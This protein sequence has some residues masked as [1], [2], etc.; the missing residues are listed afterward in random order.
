M[1]EVPNRTSQL[2]LDM[3]HT[4]DISAAF[5]VFS[6]E[7]SMFYVRY[8]DLTACLELNYEDR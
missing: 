1:E 3:K 6:T 7:S 8:A 4:G 2:L 5:T